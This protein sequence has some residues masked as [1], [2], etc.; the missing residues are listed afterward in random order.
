MNA[1]MSTESSDFM[2]VSGDVIFRPG[3]QSNPGSSWYRNEIRLKMR[4]E[5]QIFSKLI[6]LHRFRHLARLEKRFERFASHAGVHAQVRDLHH[7]REFL[8]DEETHAVANQA[9]PVRVVDERAFFGAQVR[10]VVR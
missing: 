6:P 5:L 1:L 4:R 7:A 9:D 2:Q 3:F 8:E 10:G